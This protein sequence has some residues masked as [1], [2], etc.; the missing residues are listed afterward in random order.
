MRIEAISVRRSVVLVL[1][2]LAVGAAVLAGLGNSADAA[3]GG[4]GKGGGGG[5]DSSSAATMVITP[6]ATAGVVDVS[7][8]GFKAGKDVTLY[9]TGSWPAVAHADKSGAFTYSHR[10][11]GS[12][13]WTFT[14]H[15]YFRNRW[16]LMATTVYDG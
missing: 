8:T 3:R 5:G 10:L 2:V 16:N 4:K 13:P 15:Q 11:E 7:G 12:G 14:A 9:I 1:L 6:G